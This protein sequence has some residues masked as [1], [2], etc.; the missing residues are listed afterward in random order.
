MFTAIYRWRVTPGKEEQFVDGWERVTRAIRAGCGS[1]GSRLH[2]CADGTWLGYARWPDAATRDACQHEEHEGRRLMADALDG[3]VE[4]V[5]A[6]IV[7]DLLDEPR[8]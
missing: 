8:G 2:R 6:E 7:R 4:E 5:V 1:Y 3:D